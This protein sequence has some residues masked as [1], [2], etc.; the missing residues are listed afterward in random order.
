MTI[1]PAGA[2]LLIIATQTVSSAAWI[3]Y[4]G[5]RFP[6]VAPNEVLKSVASKTREL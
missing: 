6:P 4:N 2:L 5:A 1:C 3:L